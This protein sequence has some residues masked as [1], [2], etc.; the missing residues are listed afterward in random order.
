MGTQF[1]DPV[2]FAACK[3]W[4]NFEKCK[5]LCQYFSMTDTHKYIDG[6]F[7][8]AWSSFKIM[9]ALWENTQILVHNDLKIDY[10]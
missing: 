9:K 10:I 5:L 6:D 2:K 1:I 3:I 7:I 4:L 8:K